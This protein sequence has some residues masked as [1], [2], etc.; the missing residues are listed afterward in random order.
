CQCW[1]WDG[2]PAC[3]V[4]QPGSEIKS[5]TLPEEHL[6]S[7]ELLN[8]PAEH[9][10]ASAQSDR[11]HRRDEPEGLGDLPFDECLQQQ[12]Q[13]R[14]RN[15]GGAQVQLKASRHGEADER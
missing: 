6:L 8:R 14:N 9:E 12:D 3:G 11:C 2:T 15:K 4:S 10:K 5:L 1:G 13:A 7:I